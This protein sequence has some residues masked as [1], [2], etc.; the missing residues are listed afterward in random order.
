MSKLP[1]FANCKVALETG[2]Y[3]MSD[4][5]ASCAFQSDDG[6]LVCNNNPIRWND[7]VLHNDIGDDKICCK[8]SKG[9]LSAFKTVP[10]TDPI[11]GAYYC[12][13]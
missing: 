10:E 12:P 5:F 6:S 13:A 1:A 7:G 8:D 4:G 3:V 9:T 11:A 2:T